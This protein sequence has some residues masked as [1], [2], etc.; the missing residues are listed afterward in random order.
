MQRKVAQGRGW[1][2]LVLYNR[3]Y[4]YIHKLTISQVAL[5]LLADV[6]GMDLCAL[7]SLPCA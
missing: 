6:L 2:W 3:H 1:E 4:V 7:Y 5:N